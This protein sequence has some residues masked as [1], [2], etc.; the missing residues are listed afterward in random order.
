[1]DEMDELSI[2]R[3]FFR[4][5]ANFL[6]CRLIAIDRYDAKKPDDYASL[7]EVNWICEMRI[8]IAEHRNGNNANRRSQGKIA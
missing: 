5:A 3:Q 1:M 7:G 8:L 6:Q 2:E 4:A